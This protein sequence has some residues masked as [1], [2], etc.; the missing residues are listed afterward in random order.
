M[1]SEWCIAQYSF[2]TKK[3]VSFV[4]SSHD[5]FS[6][7][8]AAGV[9]CQQDGSAFSLQT[10]EL[11]SDVFGFSLNYKTQRSSPLTIQLCHSQPQCQKSMFAPIGECLF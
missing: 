3:K 10:H 9:S 6:H 11:A 8:P 2:A 5:L 4:D 1:Q 7:L